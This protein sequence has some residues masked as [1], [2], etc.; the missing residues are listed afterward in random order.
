MYKK[1]GVEW[2]LQGWDE[3]NVDLNDIKRKVSKAASKNLSNPPKLPTHIGGIPL[4][5]Y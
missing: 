3:D 2:F 5:N 1:W 4:Q